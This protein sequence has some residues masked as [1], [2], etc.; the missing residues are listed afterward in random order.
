MVEFNLPFQPFDRT[1]Q[2]KQ[3]EG[4]RSD[5]CVYVE[6]SRPVRHKET[7][8]QRYISPSVPFLRSKGTVTMRI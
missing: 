6:P 3:E 2:C 8:L 4:N 5:L 1:A 7:G